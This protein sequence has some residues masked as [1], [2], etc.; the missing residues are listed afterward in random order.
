MWNAATLLLRIS[1]RVSHRLNGWKRFAFRVYKIGKL[2]LQMRNNQKKVTDMRH[3]NE[4]QH[5][6]TREIK[7]ET[8]IANSAISQKKRHSKVEHQ[9]KEGPLSDSNVATSSSTTPK[10]QGISLAHSVR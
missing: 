8:F 4:H 10:T 7:K 1:E 3:H 5:N 9:E 2:T 6:T